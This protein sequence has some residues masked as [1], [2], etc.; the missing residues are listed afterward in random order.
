MDGVLMVSPSK[1]PSTNLPLLVM[2]KILGIG[3][4]GVWLSSL[5]TARGDNTN[6]PCAA[7]PP[8]T[9]C[10]EKVVASSLSQGRSMAKAALVASQMV[11]PSRSAAIQSPLGTFTPL[12]VPFHT[13]TVSWVGSYCLRSGRAP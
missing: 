1:M 4:D 6:M 3:H 5:A 12:V 7:S 11:R 10:Q 8:S 2:R 9:F 13:N